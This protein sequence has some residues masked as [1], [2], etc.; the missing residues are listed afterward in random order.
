MRIV[1]LALTFALTLIAG[2]PVRVEGDDYPSRNITFLCPFPAGGGTDLLTRLLA[3]ELQDKLAKPVIVENRPG[4]GTTIAA[5]AAAK[6]APD[7][8]TIF[9]APSTTLAIAP[10]VFKSLPYDPI[11]DLAPIGWSAGRSSR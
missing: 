6:S 11:K 1:A 8:Y 5:S 9:L 2:S 3:Q 4:G 7:G 10:S